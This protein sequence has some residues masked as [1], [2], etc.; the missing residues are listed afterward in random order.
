MRFNGL[1]NKD[2]EKWAEQNNC[3]IDG[4]NRL[5][6]YKAVHKVESSTG[7][8]YISDFG[9]R[10]GPYRSVVIPKAE[11]RFETVMEYEIGVPIM[12]P[13][14]KFNPSPFMACAPGLHAAGLNYARR[15]G[16]DWG[17][18]CILE[19]GIDLSD[20]ETDVIIPYDEDAVFHCSSSTLG[21]IS[22]ANDFD[23]DTCDIFS[24]KIRTNKMTPIREVGEINRANFIYGRATHDWTFV[25][26]VLNIKKEI[27]TL[28]T[29]LYGLKFIDRDKVLERLNEL[30]NTLITLSRINWNDC[31][32]K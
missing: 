8:R 30:T 10:Y 27:K 31:Y 15:F 19:L 24:P 11:D 17:D 16:D 9:L 22:I 29:K 23:P 32:F 21:A 18:G 3:E 14:D 6:V 4:H 2:V 7:A 28:E 13:N 5:H 26:T 25:L 1:L 20:Y 12:V